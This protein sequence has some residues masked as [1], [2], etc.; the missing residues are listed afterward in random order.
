MLSTARTTSITITQTTLCSEHSLNHE[1]ILRTPQHN[2]GRGGLK[3][4]LYAGYKLS[5]NPKITVLLPQC[6]RTTQHDLRKATLRDDTRHHN[7]RHIRT[8]KWWSLYCHLYTDMER[9]C[10]VQSAMVNFHFTETKLYSNTVYVSVRN[11]KG[12]A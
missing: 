10:H 1:Q 2:V 4:M 3:T 12:Y 8:Y 5:C 6:E 11:T 7:C 9:S